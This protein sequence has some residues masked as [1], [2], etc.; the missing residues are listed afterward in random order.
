M[1]VSYRH[2]FR[3]YAVLSAF[4]I[5]ICF[6]RVGHYDW[7]LLCGSDPEPI[8]KNFKLC[9]L[10]IALFLMGSSVFDP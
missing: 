7:C 4:T 6:P 8:K 5:I 2:V 3:N 1:R 10:Y 9:S